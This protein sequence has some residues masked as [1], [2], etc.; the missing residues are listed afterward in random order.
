MH[1]K[2]DVNHKGFHD[3]REVSRLAATLKPNCPLKH[4]CNALMGI[5]LCRK[6]ICK[7][8]AY[9]PPVWALPGES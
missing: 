5:S 4:V 1:P 9:L 8:I 2:N 6:P 3:E 7:L